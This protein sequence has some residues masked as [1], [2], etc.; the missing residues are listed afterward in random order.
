[1]KY[2]CKTTAVFLPVN[3]DSDN[4]FRRGR[5]R[6]FEPNATNRRG[7]RRLFRAAELHD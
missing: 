6:E 3:D 4:F 2:Y 5:D 1:M 7:W